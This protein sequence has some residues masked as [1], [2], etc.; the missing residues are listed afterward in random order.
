VALKLN[1]ILQQLLEYLG[2]FAAGEVA[3]GMHGSNRLGGNSLTDLLGLWSP[4][5]RMGAAEYVKKNSAQIQ[6]QMQLLRLRQSES[7]A[8]FSRTGGE[9]SYSHSRP[10]SADYPQLGRNHS[11]HVLK[12]KNAIAKIA[13]T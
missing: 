5:R 8:P 1:Q 6:F 9:N 4:C 11:H 13:D 10:T 3:G 12:S 7:N 2:L